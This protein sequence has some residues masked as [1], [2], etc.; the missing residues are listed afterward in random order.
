NGLDIPRANTILIDRADH[1]GLAELHQLR[2]R[3]GRSDKK[4]YCYLLM[5]RDAPPNEDARKRLKAIE[6]FGHL[7]AGFAIAIKDLEIRG[8]GNL[9]GPQQSG[10]IAAVGYE[11]YCRLV[12][13]AVQRHQAQPRAA[14]AVSPADSEDQLEVDVDL[15]VSAYL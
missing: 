3:V 11:M 8:A 7:G 12:K 2:G 9:L 5:D 15:R 6:E 10:H 13:E 4:A 14:G 1:Y